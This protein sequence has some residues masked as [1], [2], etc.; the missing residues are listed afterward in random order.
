[1]FFL[2][3]DRLKILN[4]YQT[5]IFNTSRSHRGIHYF[6]MELVYGSRMHELQIFQFTFM[7]S[8]FHLDKANYN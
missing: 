3:L 7:F 2:S 4:V 6:Y 1:M 5:I 8:S